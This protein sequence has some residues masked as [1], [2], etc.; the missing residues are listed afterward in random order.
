MTPGFPV[1]PSE[2]PTEEDAESN[3][4]LGDG[5]IVEEHESTE[6]EES[7]APLRLR[8]VAESIVGEHAEKDRHHLP[9]TSWCFV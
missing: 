2:K 3:I 6:V 5:D 4:E 1:S 9:Y 8:R 7:R